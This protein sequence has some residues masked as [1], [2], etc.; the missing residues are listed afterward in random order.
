MEQGAP[1][2]AIHSVPPAT[3]GFDDLWLKSRDRACFPVD[4]GHAAKHATPR[5]S[6][7]WLGGGLATLQ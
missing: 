7:T 3:C 2:G 6:P 5:S 4:L 1:E